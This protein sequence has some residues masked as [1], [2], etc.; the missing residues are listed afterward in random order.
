MKKSFVMY[1]EWQP[2]FSSMTNEQAG[3]LIK[4]VYEYQ[5]GE[6]EAPIDPL[7][8]SIYQMLTSRFEIDAENYAKVCEKRKEY[9]KLGGLAKASKSYQKVAKAKTEPKKVEVVKSTYGEYKN[10]RLTEEE[11]TRL[12]SRY[13]EEDTKQGITI[14]DTYMESLS[15]AKKKEYLKKNH[16]L[17][18]QNWVYNEVEKRRTRPVAKNSFNNFTQNTYTHKEMSDLEAQLLDN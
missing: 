16:N 9:G 2:L 12:C 4:A 1:A 8:N 3:E 13:G 18:M 10:V 11:Y 5:F 17:C 15:P 14:L 6:A 7:L